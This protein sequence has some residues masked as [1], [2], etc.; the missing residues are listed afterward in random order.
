MGLS[1]PVA[2]FT[3]NAEVDPGTLPRIL[4]PFAKRGLTPKKVHVS[5]DQPNGNY[6]LIDVQMADMDLETATLI[7]RSLDQ[8]YGVQSVL[9]STKI[10]G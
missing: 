10:A 3:V 6:L 7:G 1:K 2:C 9:V 8:I 5:E 4:E